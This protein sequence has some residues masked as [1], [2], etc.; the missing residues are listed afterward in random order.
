MAISADLLEGPDRLNV[1]YHEF[2][3]K[4]AKQGH[5]WIQCDKGRISMNM[6]GTPAYFREMRE[7]LFNPG[8]LDRILQKLDD[9]TKPNADPK[10]IIAE[11]QRLTKET[12]SMLTALAQTPVSLDQRRDMLVIAIG[13]GDNEPFQIVAPFSHVAEFPDLDKELRKHAKTLGVPVRSDVTVENIITEF[14]RSGQL[15]KAQGLIINCSL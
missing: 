11:L 12:Q 15:A 6:P 13:Y 14:Q 2:L 5:A 10:A 3:K 1:E 9:L 7:D 4:F 8:T